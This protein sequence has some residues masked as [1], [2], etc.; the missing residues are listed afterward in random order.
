MPRRLPSRQIETGYATNV[1]MPGSTSPYRKSP[2]D[3]HTIYSPFR[4]PATSIITVI[5]V[6]TM[7]TVSRLGYA[8]NTMYIMYIMYIIYAKYIPTIYA[9]I[10]TYI[11]KHVS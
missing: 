1:S 4:L 11:H 8:M 7:S 5:S 3:Q 10:R 9:N 6:S 2:Q